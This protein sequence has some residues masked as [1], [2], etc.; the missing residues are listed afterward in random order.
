[1]MLSIKPKSIIFTA[2]DSFISQAILAAC[3]IYWSEKNKK[4]QW[5][6]VLIYPDN[7]CYESTI[8]LKITTTK[9]KLFTIGKKTHYIKIPQLKLIDGIRVTYA[10]DRIKELEKTK[11]VGVQ[12]SFRFKDKVW[13]AAAVSGL[14]L[15]KKGYKYATFGLFGTLYALIRWKL[16]RDPEKRKALL[17]K[18]NPFINKGFMYCCDFVIS[19]LKAGGV[20][21]VK[22]VNSSLST[23]DH[24]WCTHLKCKKTII[25]DE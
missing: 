24:C 8:K 18:H 4:T 7:K 3:D 15:E 16:T 12:T 23:P 22:D 13:I 17:R 1:M 20:K 9:K 10:D 14:M 21:Y 11:K 25:K 2:D 6:H 5:S 19:S